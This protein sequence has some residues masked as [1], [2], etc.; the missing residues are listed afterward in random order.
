MPQQGQFVQQEQFP[1]QMQMPQQGQP[2]QQWY[3]RPAF[4]PQAQP[5][6]AQA[7]AQPQAAPPE[8][9]N[10]RPIREKYV[11]TCLEVDY[12]GTPISA[13]VDTGSDVSIAGDDVARRFNWDI[14]EHPTKSVKIAND[15]DMIIY[16]A[17]KVPLRVGEKDVHSEILI[18]PDLNGLIIG[19][20]W[21]EKQGEFSWNFRDGCI[22]FENGDWL[23]LQ[24]ED[25]SRR[26]RRVYMSQEA[27]IPGSSTVQAHIRVTHSATD[28]EPFVGILEE[29]EL[30][31]F[32]DIV[33][34]RS[35]L[36]AKFADMQISLI[37][38]GETF[39]VVPKGT[40]LGVLY[41][42]QVL[43]IPIDDHYHVPRVRD[44]PPDPD[45]ID[46]LQSPLHGLHQSRLNRIKELGIDY[47]NTLAQLSVYTEPVLIQFKNDK[48]K[49][50]VTWCVDCHEYA[51]KETTDV[52]KLFHLAR[53]PEEDAEP[54]Q[55]K[56]SITT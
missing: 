40:A 30:P 14:H 47:R 1:Q 12:E 23:D 49:V 44:T 7:L 20:D 15:A 46:A 17:A 24:K 37:N 32:K 43:R 26:V 2:T 10:V 18:T 9:S 33:Y 34:T 16:G 19:V 5:P 52:D 54:P 50:Q 21:L 22:K 48:D 27:I 45:E 39:T 41:E 13:L 31:Q 29:G 4:V 55:M 42:A 6:Q 8:Q 35:L 36:P 56:V 25:A 51:V 53:P 38:L 28:D 3:F 11:K